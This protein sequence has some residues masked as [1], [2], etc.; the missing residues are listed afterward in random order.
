MELAQINLMCI[1]A[2]SLPNIYKLLNQRCSLTLYQ[3]PSCQ[4]VISSNLT[5]LFI[6]LSIIMFFN[7]L[8][9]YHINISSV[10]ALIQNLTSCPSIHQIIYEYKSMKLGWMQGIET[11]QIEISLT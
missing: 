5:V 2:P 7:V 6:S 10:H 8:V 4:E 11:F 9:L 1:I 3:G